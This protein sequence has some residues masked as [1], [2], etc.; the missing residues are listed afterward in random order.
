MDEA[1][2]EALE[3]ASEAQTLVL[4]RE[5]NLLDICWKGRMVGHQQSR[6]FLEGTR[7]NFLKQALGGPTRVD[8]QLH[9]LFTDKGEQVG[10]MRISNSLGCS[11]HEMVGCELL[12]GERKESS[13]KQ[14][15]DFRR[16]DFS[17]FRKLVG[18]I[19]GEA[20]L[21]DEGAEVSHQA[22]KV[23]MVQV[24]EWSGPHEDIRRLLWVNRKLTVD[25]QCKKASY[26]WWKQGHAMKEEFRNIA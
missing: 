17:T 21:K 23:S 11:R 6:R 10:E 19:P 4:M 1:F 20:A 24:Q 25:L 16:A 13:R 22:F 9:L 15:L 18:G 2:F 3:E 26:W 12:G 7:D 5:F 14:T 8:P